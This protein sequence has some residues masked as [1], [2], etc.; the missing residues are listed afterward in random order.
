MNSPHNLLKRSIH[1]SFLS[2]QD[3][4]DPVI[5]H[6]PGGNGSAGG[7]GA[8]GGGDTGGNTGG[9]AGN[10]GGNS[11]SVS[12]PGPSA[13]P[14]PSPSNSARPSSSPPPAPSS[15]PRPSS[16]TARPTPSSPS[17]TPSA[18]PTSTSQPPSSSTTASSTAQSSSSAS[19]SASS[20]TGTTSS[21]A[22]TVARTIA[23]AV[24][25]LA[26][27]GAPI[28][29]SFRPVTQTDID[30]AGSTITADP[31]DANGGSSA[32]SAG[33]IAGGVIGGLIALG[34]LGF[35]IATF[36]RRRSRQRRRRARQQ[37]HESDFGTFNRSAFVK[38]KAPMDEPDTV[39]DMAEA[40]EEHVSAGYGATGTAIPP[41]QLAAAAPA[42]AKVQ[43][44]P[45]YVFGQSP[46]GSTGSGSDDNHNAAQQQHGDNGEAYA[47]AYGSDPHA[48]AAYN[49]EAYGSYAQYT[50]AAGGAGY[51]EAERGY[52]AQQGYDQ[53]Q[54]YVQQQPQGYYDQSGVWVSYDQT[55]G[56]AYY[57]QHQQQ[58]YDYA[59]AYDQYVTQPGQAVAYQPEAT[60][61]QPPHPYAH[62][63]ATRGDAA[64]GGM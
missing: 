27:T 36:L 48:Q 6:L 43:E 24:V 23:P 55:A 25:P 14:S 41:S 52:Q 35:V 58:Q 16:T 34:V 5:P 12:S 33:P 62:T 50:D 40:K 11:G 63:G 31:A 20:T 1:R 45:K 29:S 44:R 49:A 64:Y 22:T 15:T 39:P 38:P 37:Q 54:E 42:P 51:Q 46:E 10:N 61:Y 47:G 21:T 60:A 53:Q 17:P 19:V 18:K 13:S 26:N 56:G 32:I 28:A 59:Q 9:G 2:R 7:N 57:D 4:G 8:G 30:S 3:K